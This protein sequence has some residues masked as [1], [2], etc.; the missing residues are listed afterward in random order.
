M[1][2]KKRSHLTLKERIAIEDGLRER[3]SV[4]SIARSVEVCHTTVAREIRRHRTQESPRYRVLDRNLC[5]FKGRCV[6][7]GVCGLDCSEQC[8]S[9]PG[10]ACNSACNEFEPIGECPSLEKAP[11]ACNGCPR[12]LSIGCQ[13]PQWFYD[14]RLADEEARWDL[15]SSRRGIDC[16][17]EQLKAMC[18]I[19]RPLLKKGQSLEHIWQKHH[20]EMPV[21]FRTFYRYVNLGV[22]DVINLDLP[23][24]VRYRPR[25]KGAAAVPFK[26]NLLGR[27]Y[28]D[29]KELPSERQW[30]AVEM[31]CVVPGRGGQKAILTLHLRRLCFQLM[32]LMPAH[33]AGCVKEALDW[34]EMLC[35]KDQFQSLF[36]TILTDRGS[37]FLC[38]ASLEAGIDGNK[39]CHIYY[40]DPLQSG[41]KG[42]CE[43]N[44][45]EL[46][47]ILPKGTRFDDLTN[48]EMAV[49]CSHVNSYGRPALG[50]ACPFD[51]AEKVLPRD[52]LEGLALQRVPSDEVIMRPSLLRQIGAR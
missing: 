21:S 20:L 16:T 30:S 48:R 38:Y 22:L 4:N 10:G 3:A 18:D 40:C 6:V 11:Y 33:T 37:E 9:C 32:I 44:H 12:R 42:R 36:G 2:R 27:T 39:R 31:D 24:K 23:R 14:A 15:S 49:I 28:G 52:L 50:G 7:T 5:R 41:Q 43:K 51:L 34:V 45:V 46:R 25:K 19:V 35:G 26:P 47:K 29:F 13:Y 8:S 17:E 1:P